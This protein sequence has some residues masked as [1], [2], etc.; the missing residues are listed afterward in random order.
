MPIS[1]YALKGTV[2]KKKG[3]HMD[4]KAIEAKQEMEDQKW[5]ARVVNKYQPP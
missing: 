5:M 4:F 1:L 2:A 3:K